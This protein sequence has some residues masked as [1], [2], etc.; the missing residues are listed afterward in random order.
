[1][2]SQYFLKPLLKHAV[3]SIIKCY[4]ILYLLNIHCSIQISSSRYIQTEI[5]RKTASEEARSR[6]WS[7]TGGDDTGHEEN[8][9]K[10]EETVQR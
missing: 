8:C 1:M 4:Y 9:N 3:V 6:L 5:E 2:T 10:Q 7:Y